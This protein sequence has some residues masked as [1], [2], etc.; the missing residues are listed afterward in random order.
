M[1]TLA[2]G[3]T[4]IASWLLSALSARQ[5]LSSDWV[6]KSMWW[7]YCGVRRLVRSTRFQTARLF[8]AWIV[9]NCPTILAFRSIHICW[10]R[11]MSRELYPAVLCGFMSNSRYQLISLRSLIVSLVLWCL[12]Y[13]GATLACLLARWF[14]MLRH[15]LFWG[16]TSM[17]PLLHNLYWLRVPFSVAV[18]VYCCRHELA[19]PYLASRCGWRRV[20]TAAPISFDYDT[21]CSQY[22]A[23]NIC[24]RSFFVAAAW[25]WN[26]LS[27]LV[28]SSPLL[29]AIFRQRI[30]TEQFIQSYGSG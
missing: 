14:W 25:V 16:H 11:H 20:S 3:L 9:L 23:L 21:A 17:I 2:V 12:N 30:W 18:L 6:D 26:S 28:T 8:W 27:Q 5:Y 1:G 24:D 15:D 10:C 22:Y 19:P 29:T 4:R 7:C 13:G